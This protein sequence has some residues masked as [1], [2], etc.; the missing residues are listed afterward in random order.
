M[1]EALIATD[2]LTFQ[3]KIQIFDGRHIQVGLTTGTKIGTSTS[4][5][6]SVYGVTP[7]DQASAI[8]APTGGGSGV[9]AAIDQSARTAI[10]LIRAALTNFGITA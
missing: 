9:A 7:V 3:K 1:L 8:A 5:K 10:N 4:Q 2:R 6:L